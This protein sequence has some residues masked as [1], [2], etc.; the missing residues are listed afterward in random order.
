MI[1]RS[2]SGQRGARL[3]R[4]THVDDGAKQMLELHLLCARQHGTIDN[5]IIYQE[6]NYTKL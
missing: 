1:D 4:N 3:A 5:A 6:S 2:S